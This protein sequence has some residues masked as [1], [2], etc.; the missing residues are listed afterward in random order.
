MEKARELDPSH[1]D[2]PGL[3]AD[4][5]AA[6]RIEPPASFEPP[7]LA[8]VPLV[9]APPP[10]EP[11]PENEI[12]GEVDEFFA[13]VES[14]AAEATEEDTTVAEPSIEQPQPPVPSLDAQPAARLDSE[15]EQRIDDLLNE[16]QES[17]ETGQ[18]Q[19]AI[20]AWSRI[21][22]IDIDHAEASRRIELARKLKAEVE[23]QTEEAFHEGITRLESG[24][25]E[26]AKEAFNSVL[27]MQPNHMG[28]RDYLDKIE[29]GDLSVASGAIP[30][31][32]PVVEAPPEVEP[33]EAQPKDQGDLTPT[34]TPVPSV[35]DGFD[36][37][38][39]EFEPV[40]AA[41]APGKRSFALIG[42]AVL[43]LLLAVG[44]F[45]YSNW[46]RFFPASGPEDGA[47]TGQ[48]QTDPIAR[49]RELHEAGNTAMAINVLRRLPPGN[50]QYAEAQAMIA[51][52]ESGSQPEDESPSNEPSQEALALRDELLRLAQQ[53]ISREEHLL[54]LSLL[55]QADAIKDLEEDHEALQN[56]ANVALDFLREERDLF[57][58]GTG[59]MPYPTC[60]E[61]T[62]TAGAT[63]TSSA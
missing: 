42:S 46:N 59:S 56:K 3:E 6:S 49:A 32:A 28:A 50:D 31:L 20:D 58:Q 26:G 37:S 18:Y 19:T 1:P 12:A 48:S 33:A 30:E 57:D 15:S 23:R 10:V 17:F 24:N 7:P 53:A 44:W 61:C 54:A 35:L 4:I 47:T 25:E 63:Q 43:I 14:P 40:P 51:A 45:V 52:W 13:S 39:P 29:S 11:D 38:E 5:E 60:G 27:E 8:E 55:A 62:T 21:F 22:L 16:G 34:P 36:A 9:E 2:L 41:P